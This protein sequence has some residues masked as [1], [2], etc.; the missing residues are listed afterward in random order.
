MATVYGN[1]VVTPQTRQA[2]GGNAEAR[3]TEQTQLAISSE[4]ARDAVAISYGGGDQVL[5]NPGRG[6]YISGSGNLAVRLVDA[7]VDTQFN[8]L[9]AGVVYPF[10]VAIIRQAGSS[11]SGVVLL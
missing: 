4:S 3:V 6:I 2:Q 1:I 5:T 10:M 8:G 11:A 9:L 7:S